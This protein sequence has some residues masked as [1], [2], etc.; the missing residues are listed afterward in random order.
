MNKKILLLTTIYPASDLKYGTPSI[1]YFTKEWVK[2][3]YEVRVVHFQATYP[4]FFYFL[5][6]FFRDKIA[7]LTGAVVF[8]E[9]E[10]EDK[11]YVMD[12]VNIY[13]N[14]IFKWIPH[15][16][17]TR[18][19]MMTQVKKIVAMNEK[20][21]FQPSIIIGHFSNPQLK[22]VSELKK[23]YQ[24]RTCMIMH[25]IGKSIIKTYK[26]E[27]KKLMKDIDIWGFRSKPIKRGFEKIFGVPKESFYCYSGIPE[28]YILDV[29]NRSFN[30]DLSTFVYVGEFIKRKFAISI[31]PA[32]NEA[33]PLKNFKI[34]FVGRGSELGKMKSITE[35]LSLS[36]NISF[37]G[38]VPRDEIVTILDDADCMIMIS[39]NEAFGL[40]YL[41]AMARGCITIGSLNEGIDGIINHGVNGF[42]CQAGSEKDLTRLILHI[43]S[44]SSMKRLEI[45]QNAIRTAKNLTDNMAAHKYISAL[46]W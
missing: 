14:P 1:H 43:N 7:S 26:K 3:G 44:L 32:I 34:N 29:K 31:I 18:K 45:S 13:R 40:V 6:S 42:L 46:D 16:R 37:L 22:I 8:T 20:D 2:M 17:Y 38:H 11:H 25:D 9:R 5:A 36:K 28:S 39:K 35:A 4:K 19:S 33:Y 30:G 27:Y 24:A 21:N 41:E 12:E 10:E 23:I 15:G